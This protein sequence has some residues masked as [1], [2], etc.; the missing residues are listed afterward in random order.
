MFPFLADKFSE[1]YLNQNEDLMDEFEKLIE[2]PLFD[3]L[4]KEYG[5]HTTHKAVLHVLGYCELAE[6]SPMTVLSDET[7]DLIRPRIEQILL[8]AKKLLD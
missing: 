3:V 7:I 2:E 1:A 8:D 4:V 5:W 6:R